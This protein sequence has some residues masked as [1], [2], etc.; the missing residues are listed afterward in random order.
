MLTVRL[1]YGVQLRLENQLITATGSVKICSGI[2]NTSRDRRARHRDR[3]LG[4]TDLVA[5]AIST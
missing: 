5:N 2:I 3:R 4:N 1:T